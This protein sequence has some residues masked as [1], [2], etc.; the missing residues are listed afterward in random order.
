[1]DINVDAM[2]REQLVQAIQFL[3]AQLTIAETHGFMTKLEIKQASEMDPHGCTMGGDAVRKWSTEIQKA[4]DEGEEPPLQVK[5][6]VSKLAYLLHHTEQIA[7]LASHTVNT[8]NERIVETGDFNRESLPIQS[9]E[10]FFDFAK[11]VYD[12]GSEVADLLEISDMRRA[13]A[14]WT[15]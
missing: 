3:T 2:D 10:K 6:L 5:H 1:M 7:L 9:E 12:T 14:Q 11:R 4:Y 8:L 15:N 13:L